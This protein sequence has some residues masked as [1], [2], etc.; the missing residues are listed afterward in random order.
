MEQWQQFNRREQGMLLLVAG[1]AA[2][3]L[4]WWVV[5]QPLGAMVSKQQDDNRI[6]A[7]QLQQAREMASQLQQLKRNSAGQRGPGAGNLQRLVNQTAGSHS[8]G[9]SDFRPNS[10]G[11]LQ[12]RF[13]RAPFNNVLKWLYQLESAH[14]IMVDNLNVT[15]TPD[16]GVVTVSVRL[17]SR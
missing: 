6:L 1:A 11:S 16:S 12:L 17:R 7:G 3:L 5:L 15:P 13:D 14:R 4:L 8:L 10:D 9:V 2:L